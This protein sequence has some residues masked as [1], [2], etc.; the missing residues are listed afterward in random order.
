M[1]EP[2]EGRRPLAMDPP[3]ITEFASKS[4]FEKYQQQQE[5]H[6][7]QQD[8]STASSFNIPHNSAKF[9]LPLRE[10]KIVEPLETQKPTEQKR[11]KRRLFSIRGRVAAIH[12]SKPVSLP[13]SVGTSSQSRLSTDSAT[14][15]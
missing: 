2:R 14:K 5:H 11:D 1:A 9:I 13:V 6:L 4:Y 7:Q 12:S 8:A 10:S 15:R 3:H